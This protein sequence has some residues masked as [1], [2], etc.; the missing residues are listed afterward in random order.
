[1]SMKP[2][3]TGLITLVTFAF[4]S[5]MPVFAIN[6]DDAFQN[7][8][9]IQTSGLKTEP[10]KLAQRTNSKYITVYGRSICPITTKLIGELKSRR[11]PYNVKNVDNSVDNDELYQV[12]FE[13]DIN[14]TSGRL[15]YVEV[16]GKLLMS[17]NGVRIE[18]VISEL[19]IPSQPIGTSTVY[20]Y[21]RPD[22]KYSNKF[23]TSMQRKQIPYQFNNL[24]DPS[25][26]NEFWDLLKKS[27]N[28]SNKVRLPV[29]YVNEK[30]M[31]DPTL[32][33]V[34]TEQSRR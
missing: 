31:V 32:K 18:Q 19:S 25:N 8:Q 16:N 11:I 30:V 2:N 29:I 4:S 33:Q 23:I 26:E 10:I 22:D 27:G 3:F 24:N 15:P 9:V 13:N 1:M 21:S 34:L 7:N 6:N 17:S 5:G 14:S 20:I 28:S 12:A